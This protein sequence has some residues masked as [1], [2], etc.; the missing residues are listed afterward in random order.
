[1][2]S[3]TTYLPLI[4]NCLTKEISLI[5]PVLQIRNA[6]GEELIYLSHIPYLAAEAGLQNYC[7]YSVPIFSPPSLVPPWKTGFDEVCDFDRSV[8]KCI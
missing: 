6:Q 7:I 1:M 3:R 5:A 2:L 8:S 4:S